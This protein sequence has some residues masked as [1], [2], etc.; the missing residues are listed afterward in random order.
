SS[1][2]SFPLPANTKKLTEV[3]ECNKNTAD[4]H[5]PRDSRLIRL[6]GIHP[7]N[8]EAPL[9]ALY[10]SEFLTPTELWYIRNHGVVPKVLDNEIFIWKFTIEGLVGQPMVFEL[11][12]LFKF[13]QVTSSITLVCASN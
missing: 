1:K 10:D 6:T 7:F 4:S 13:C 9:S 2:I 11:N 8:Y 5:V 3:L 12:E